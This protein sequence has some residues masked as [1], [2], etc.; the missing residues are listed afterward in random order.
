MRQV[1][2]HA[3]IRDVFGEDDNFENDV[4]ELYMFEYERI[5]ASRYVARPISYRTREGRWNKLLYDQEYLNET[6]FLE[7]FRVRRVTFHRLVDLVK[8]DPV[9]QSRVNRAFRGNAALH[10]MILLKTLGSSGNANTWSKL[11]L[12][13]GLGKGSVGVYLRRATRALIKLRSST[14]TW[15]NQEERKEIARRIQDKYGFVN[16]VGMTDRTLF[17]LEFK[18]TAN[19]E[20][21]YCRKGMYAVNA[22]ITCDDLARVRDIVVGWPGSVHDNRVW[23]NSPLHLDSSVYFKRNEYVLG[24][25]AFQASAVMI[26]AF[27]KPPGRNWTRTSHTSIQNSQRQGSRVSTVLAY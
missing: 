15:S 24:D 1:A 26:P 7:H 13:F 12:F 27:K 3:M 19:G 8:D 25:S 22:V 10:L 18:P 21:Y 23:S 5:S 16:C 2:L 17:P 6:E 4:D 11:A 14:V 9:L 20:D